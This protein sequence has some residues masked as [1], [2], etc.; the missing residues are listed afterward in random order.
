MMEGRGLSLSDGVT[1]LD[2]L[3]R[4]MSPPDKRSQRHPE[5]YFTAIDNLVM[6]TTAKSWP[7]SPHDKRHLADY[8]LISEGGPPSGSLT[9]R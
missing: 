5:I 6:S 7:I 4:G 2:P 9:M 8:C 1:G 3:R